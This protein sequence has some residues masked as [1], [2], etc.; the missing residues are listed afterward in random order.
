LGNLDTK[1]DIN[2]ALETIGEN[3]KISAKEDLGYCKSKKH[4]TCFDERSSELSGKRK[5]DKF[6]FLM[7]FRD[8]VVWIGLIWF[9]IGTI[10]EPL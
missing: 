9:R 3:I 10:G 6:K 1:V 7:D 4:K 2:R 5:Q 8:I